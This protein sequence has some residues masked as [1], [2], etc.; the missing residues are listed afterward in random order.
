MDSPCHH[1]AKRPC[2][3]HDTCKEYQDFRAEIDK[4]RKEN[5]RNSQC[6]DYVYIS[7]AKRKRRE[8]YK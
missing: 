1:C 8:R 5:M 7:I 3:D 6:K 2:Y 4:R